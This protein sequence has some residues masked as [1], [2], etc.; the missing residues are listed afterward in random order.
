MKKF[1]EILDTLWNWV[2]DCGGVVGLCTALGFMIATF[3][4]SPLVVLAPA[5][6]VLAVTICTI[7]GFVIGCTV[8]LLFK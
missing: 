8:K 2:Y 5:T 3:V 4:L 7:I 6:Y 1:L